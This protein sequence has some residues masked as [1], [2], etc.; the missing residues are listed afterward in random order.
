MI[1]YIIIFIF[2]YKL[3]RLEETK[4]EK[5][6]VIYNKRRILKFPKNENKMIN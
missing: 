6:Y 1:I 2:V 5:N 3:Y 4:K